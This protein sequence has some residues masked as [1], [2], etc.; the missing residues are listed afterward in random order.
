MNFDLFFQKAKAKGIEDV[1]VYLVN[2]SELS[3]E[4]FNGEL[5]KYEIA[6]TAS[7]SIKGVY[8]KKMAT[9][10]TEDLG[11]ELID[12]IIENLIQNASVIDSLDEA[13]IYA[14][15]DHYETLD[16]LYNEKLAKLDVAKKIAA[17]KDLDKLFHSA[18]PRIT[19]A[20]TMYSETT[21]SVLLQNTKGL[22]LQNKVNSAMIGGSIIAKNES[23][24]RTGFDLIIS[25]DFAD[26]DL[27]KIAA[28]AVSS[29]VKKLGA[30]PVVS[31]PYEIV[32]E[33]DAFATLLSAFANVFSAEAVQKNMSLLKGK[34]GTV[35]GAPLFTLVDD[36]FMKKSSRSRS[37]D[38]EGVATKYKELIKEGVLATYL[39]NLNTAK[40][41]GVKST[42]NGFGTSVA[43]INLKVL[44]GSHKFD[45]LVAS[46]VDGLLITDLQGAHAGANPVSGDF[47]LQATG[48]VVENGVVKQPVALIT[49][50]GNFITMLKDIVMVSD[51]LKTGYYG[52]T[53]PSVKI[54]SMAVSGI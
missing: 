16:D 40:K 37:F 3:M 39:H 6:D 18:D 48:F 45:D 14:G 24:Q 38:D 34:L 43:P 20:E 10:V 36:P 31:K 5:D 50:A 29:T 12:Q 7:L 32:L 30:K 35:I 44:P 47:S 23:D 2:R 27:A 21:R 1:Q 4:V 52:I 11:D 42:G 54:K 26:F 49:I 15:D 28:E 41:D 33:K 17:V 22:K 9:Y 13:I 25:N 53:C 46:T 51:D 8:Q 19:I